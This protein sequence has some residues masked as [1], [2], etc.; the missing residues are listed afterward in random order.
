M[1]AV[2]ALGAT[3]REQLSDARLLLESAAHNARMVERLKGELDEDA[4]QALLNAAA[5]KRI[6]LMLA[7]KG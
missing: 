3:G 6:K 4:E 1:V 5:L 7:G 2:R